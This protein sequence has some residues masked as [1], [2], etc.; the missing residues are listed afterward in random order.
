M[1]R[2]QRGMALLLVLVVV[3]LL[4]TLLTEF[5]FSTLVDLRLAE[6][7]RDSTRAYYLAKGGINAGSMLLKQDRNRHDSLDETWHQ[8]VTNY[9]VGDGAVTIRIED[10]GGKL[11]INSLVD[12]YNPQA[13]VVDRFYRFFSALEL[14][15]PIDPAELTAALVDWLDSG[16]DTYRELR[17]G[18]RSIAVSGAE[19]SYY[20]SLAPP[21]L[22]KNGPLH[23]LD[24][25]VNVKGFTPE[26]IQRIA[27]HL[28]VNGDHKI[29]INTAGL[30]VLMSLSPLVDRD[31]AQKIADYRAATP[32]DNLAQLEGILPPEVFVDLKT[33]GNLGM[34]GT[35]GNIYRIEA[36]ASVNDGQR[37]IVAEVDKATSRVLFLKVD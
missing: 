1:P 7:F 27:P 35:T 29:N 26:V 33:Q 16:E 13:V 6:T 23:T 10:L 17:T 31:T 20:Q 32:I 21:Y 3:V 24:E 11:A 34:L 30:E 9:P 25:L 22:C 37:R 28:A 19:N 4:T 2:R 36:H 15:P 12:D 14:P 8:G 18:D 5:A